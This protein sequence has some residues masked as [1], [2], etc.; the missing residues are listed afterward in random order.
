MNVMKLGIRLPG[1]PPE[2]CKIDARMFQDTV[3]VH[4]DINNKQIQPIDR[5][6]EDRAEENKMLSK[7]LERMKGHHSKGR[8]LLIFVMDFV[9]SFVEPRHVV[10]TMMPVVKIVHENKRHWNLTH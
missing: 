1:L 8:R 10:Q 9:K 4:V 2:I 3:N 5:E 7:L 6:E